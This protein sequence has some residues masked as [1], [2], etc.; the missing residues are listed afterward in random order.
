MSATAPGAT[1]GRYTLKRKLGEGTFAEVW[2]ATEQGDLGFR[3]EVALKILR[4]TRQAA[5]ELAALLKEASICAALRHPNIVGVRRVVEHDGLV[6]VV[7]E[8]VE[9]GTLT[10]LMERT[11]A[12]GLILP[13]SVVLD[14]GIDLARG[15]AHAWGGA[16]EDGT[17]FGVVHRDLKPANILL[18]RSGEAQIADF[19]IA[20]AAGD[21]TATAAGM[22]KGT[23]AYI[24]PEIWQG[25][26]DFCPA[27]D[28]FAVG[29]ILF[30]LATLRRLFGGDSIVE[31]FASVAHG[32]AAE[33]V[34]PVRERFPALAPVLE[35]LLQRDP[36]R[37]LQSAGELEELLVRIR[38]EVYEGLDV[39][40]FVELLDVVQGKRSTI[41]PPLLRRGPATDED[42]ERARLRALEVEA[43]LADTVDVGAVDAPEER[44]TPTTPPVQQRTPG[45]TRLM[46]RSGRGAA[47]GWWRRFIGPPGAIV[48]AAVILVVAIVVFRA[49]GERRASAPLEAEDASPP[50]EVAGEV[51]TVERA[52]DAAGFDN[53]LAEGAP[54][55]RAGLSAGS[56][57]PTISG[58]RRGGAEHRA[59]AGRAG[60]EAREGAPQ[61]PPDEAV[62][63]A[64][65]PVVPAP[66]PAAIAV[67]PTPTPVAGPGCLVFQSVP[68]GAQVWVDGEVT[69]LRARSGTGASIERT[70]GPVRVQMGVRGE[71]AA[72]LTV[73][74][75]AG[76]RHVVRCD[77]ARGTGCEV[78]SMTGTCR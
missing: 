33:D 57:A 5:D 55:E 23:P 62:T 37:R 21:A 59:D 42:W 16:R 13:R 27:V 9:G 29:C 43:A 36:A 26:R 75:R 78:S 64:S 15:L 51:G 54:T 1:L 44:P 66:S 69:G 61:P 70:A 3:A 67:P 25:G 56:H 35:R 74:V 71:P 11:S 63:P 12:Q 6:L 10:D 53:S 4:P 76:R 65:L 73:T 18:A 49:P 19:G 28:L 52:H 2:R 39:T 58:G 34:A 48:V 14:I 46:P 17:T 77:L 32:D 50:E 20:R 24:A 7:M 47:S 60:S 8:L 31:L 38:A 68:A 41:A 72:E 22:L 40:A 45:T 30:E